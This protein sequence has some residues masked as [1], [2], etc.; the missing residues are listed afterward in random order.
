MD[1]PDLV[2]TLRDRGELRLTVKVT[3]KSARSG[4]AGW[5]SGGVLKVRVQAPAERGKANAELRELLA[6]Q[7]GVPSR[8]V[9]IVSGETSPLKQVVV[10]R[11]RTL[12]GTDR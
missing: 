5:M 12:S 2:K 9:S 8:D 11:S 6:R 7:F 1:L 4:I 3:P 10:R